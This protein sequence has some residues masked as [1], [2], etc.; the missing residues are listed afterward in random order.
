MS[1]LIGLLLGIIISFICVTLYNNYGQ[2]LLER[3][4]KGLSEAK[5]KGLSEAKL[6]ERV[7]RKKNCQSQ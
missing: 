6:K 5:L 2:K 1:F 4:L 7:E 3:K